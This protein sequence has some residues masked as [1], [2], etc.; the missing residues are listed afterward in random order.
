MFAA[1]WN[2]VLFFIE[3]VT[4]CNYFVLYFSLASLTD[5][6]QNPHQKNPG[7]E[8][9]WIYDSKEIRIYDYRIN[10]Y[11]TSKK[12]PMKYSDPEDFIKCHNPENRH[13]RKRPEMRNLQKAGSENSA[14]TKLY[15]GIKLT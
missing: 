6:K 8:G 15:Q 3:Y 11:Y 2:S 10:V 9:A 14:M 12:N 13:S 4:I 7:P 5:L 1:I